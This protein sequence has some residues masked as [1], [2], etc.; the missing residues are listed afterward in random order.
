[1]ATDRKVDK[2]DH[3]TAQTIHKTDFVQVNGGNLYYEVRGSKAAAKR[4]PPIILVHGLS[5]DNRMWDRQFK[6]FSKFF[7]TYR[8]DIRGHGQSD[9]VTG[10]GWYK[11]RG[12][13]VLG[14]SSEAQLARGVGGDAVP[15]GD[16]LRYL[17]VL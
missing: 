15:K 5:L 7:L 17:L 1:M 10:P 14:P 4:F 2:S 12:V 3:I 16:M 11:P 13:L 6:I 8:Y 9:P